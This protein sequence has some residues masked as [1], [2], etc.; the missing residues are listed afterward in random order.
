MLIGN[1]VGND[2]GDGV[3]DVVVDGFGAGVWSLSISYYSMIV[4]VVADVAVSLLI[5]GDGIWAYLIP[6]LMA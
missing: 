3:A 1:S 4:G 5:L 6:F 2:V